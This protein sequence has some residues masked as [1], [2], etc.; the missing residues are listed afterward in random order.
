[1][2]PQLVDDLSKEEVIKVSCGAFHTLAL[3]SDGKLYAFGQ[4]K[5]GKLGLGSDERSMKKR[6]TPI[7]VQTYLIEEDKDG[8]RV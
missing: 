4:D 7:L 3:T 8:R 6:S 1:M 5:Y 2:S